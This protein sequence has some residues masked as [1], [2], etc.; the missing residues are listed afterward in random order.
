MFLIKVCLLS[1]D[2]LDVPGFP[3]FFG[4]ISCFGVAPLDTSCLGD[5]KKWEETLDGLYK[6]DKKFREN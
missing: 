2:E 4:E 5:S 3:D 1:E 6:D